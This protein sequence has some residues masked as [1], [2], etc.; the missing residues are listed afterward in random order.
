FKVVYAN[1]SSTIAS[2]S[3]PKS[4]VKSFSNGRFMIAGDPFTNTWS[5]GQYF[6]YIGVHSYSPAEPSVALGSISVLAPGSSTTTIA[7]GGFEQVG[8]GAG[9]FQYAPSGSAW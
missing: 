2:A 7:D 9:Q 8:V 1:N 3:V 4:S 6:R 5:G